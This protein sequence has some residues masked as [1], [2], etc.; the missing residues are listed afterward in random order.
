MGHLRPAPQRAGESSFASRLKESSAWT[1]AARATMPGYSTGEAK[2]SGR[3]AFRNFGICGRENKRK[4]VFRLPLCQQIE[5]QP[6]LR[7]TVKRMTV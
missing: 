4:P 2:S 5:K 7:M 3:R 6:S 1:L